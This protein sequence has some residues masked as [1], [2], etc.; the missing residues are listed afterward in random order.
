MI[1][2][3]RWET[4]KKYRDQSQFGG[5]RET[6]LKRDNYACVNCG[7][8][9]AEHFK[10]Y[11]RDLTVDHIDGKGRNAPPGQKN[12]ALENLQTLCIVCHGYKD[13]RRKIGETTEDK[14]SRL[15]RTFFNLIIYF[16]KVNGKFPTIKQ[17]QVIL[18]YS[19]TFISLNMTILVER[20]FLHKKPNGRLSVLPEKEEE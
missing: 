10:K 16:N 7:M 4:N 9:Q 17:L 1:M 3:T 20:G 18:P 14:L 8:T 6:V 15:Q 12:N 2:K 13:N 19:D 5:M 11:K